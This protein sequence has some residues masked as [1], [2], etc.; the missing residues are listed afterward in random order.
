MKLMKLFRT[1][2][3]NFNK[4]SFIAFFIIAFDK[5]FIIPRCFFNPLKAIYRQ[6]LWNCPFIQTVYIPIFKIWWFF[7]FIIILHIFVISFSILINSMR[8]SSSKTSNKS[9]FA[10][11]ISRLFAVLIL[12]LRKVLLDL[13]HIF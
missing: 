9:N 8:Y 10:L 6:L 2:N 7:I 12:G 11:V 13:V 3:I 4:I 5:I 1:L